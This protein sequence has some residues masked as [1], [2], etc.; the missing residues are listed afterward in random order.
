MLGERFWSKVDKTE[1]CWNW[2]SALDNK[3]YPLFFMDGQS[4]RAQRLVYKEKFGSIPDN[5]VVDHLCRNHKCLNPFHLRLLTNKENILIGIGIT[6][7][8]A[9]KT[10][11]K[12]GHELVK[13]PYKSHLTGRHCPTCKLSLSRQR[14]ERRKLLRKE[15]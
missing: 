11:C 4:R 14:E 5:L 2:K 3:G 10:L 6:A 9:R 7:Q 12:N 15:K 8:N 1:N 13:I